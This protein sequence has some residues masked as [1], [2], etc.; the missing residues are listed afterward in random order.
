M[1][2]VNDY[3]IEKGVL[4]LHGSGCPSWPDHHL[5]RDKLG[6]RVWFM[7]PGCLRNH[8]GKPAMPP[9]R[10]NVNAQDDEVRPTH[11]MRTHNRA[12]TPEPVPT[13]GVPPILTSPHRAPRTG[14]NHTQLHE[15]EVSNTEFRQ[16]IHMLEYTLKFK[17]LARYAPEMTSSM[18]ARMRKF[19]SGLSDDLVLECHR[20]ML[21]RDMDFARMSVHMQQVEEKKKK[22]PKSRKKDRQAKRARRQTR[23]IVSNRVEK[24][25]SPDIVT[26]MLQI[27]SCDMYVLLDPRSILSYVTPY[28][29]VSFG[30]E[31][32]VITESFLV[33]TPVGDSVVATRSVP[34]V[35]KFLEV[36][37]D[38]LPGIPPDREIDFCINLLPDTRPISI[39]PCSMAP[40]ELKKLKEQLAELLDKGI[41]V[42]PQKIEAVRKWPRPTTPTDIRSFLG[43]ACYYRRFI[44]NFSSIAAPLTKLTLKKVKFLWSDS[45]EN[46]FEKLKD[47]LT[48]API[49]TL[50]EG[51]KEVKEKQVEDPILIQIKKDVGQQ[52]VLSFKIGGDGVLRYQGRLCVPDVDGLRKRILDEAHTSRYVVHP[53]STKMYQD[54]KNIYW[55]NNMKRDVANYVAKCLN[56]QQVKVEHMRPGTNHSGEDY[57]KLFIAEIVHLHR[58]PVSIISDRGSQFSSHLWRSFQ[59]GLGTQVNLSMAFHPQTDG[60]VERTIHTLEDMLRA[61]VIDFKAQ[62]H[63]KSYAD[64]RRRDL[65]F[66]VGDWVFLKVSPM[67][68]VIRFRKKGKLSPHYIGPYQIMRRIGGVAYNL[69]LPASLG[70]VHSVFH[71]SMLKKYIGDHSLVFPIEEI[72]VTDSLSYEEE[73]VQILDRQV[74]RLRNKE[75]ASVKVLWRNQKI[76]EATWESEVDMRARYPNLFDP[77]DDE[78]DGSLPNCLGNIT[79][80]R[81][82]HLGSNKLSANIP[83]SLGNLQDL[84]VLYLS[85]NNMVGSLPPEIRNLK[86]ATLIDLST[87]QF[88]NGIPREIGGLRT[89]VHLSLKHNKFQGS[90]P[91]SVR[92]M[93][94]LEFLDL[95]NNNISGIIPMSFEKLPNLKYFNV[96]LSNFLC[97]RNLVKVITSCSNLDFKALV[98][99]YMPNGSLE[100]YLFSHNYFLDISQRLSIVIDVACAL[101]YLH[102]GCSSPVIH[103]DLKPSNV[104]LDEYMV[105]HLCEFGISK[106]LGEDE[107]DLYNKTLATLGYIAPEYGRDG[108]V[109]TKC[110]VYSYGIIFLETFTRRKP[111]EFEGDLSLKQWL[112]DSE[113]VKK[114]RSKFPADDL[115]ALKKNA[116]ANNILVCG[117][118]PFEYNR[119]STYTTAKKIWDALVN[120]HK[121]TSQVRKFKIALLFTEF[122]VFKMK[123]NESLHE[124]VTR[125][126]VLTNELT[127]LGKV[128]TEEEQVEKE[129]DLTTMTLDELV[130]NLR[131][132]EMEIYGTNEKATPVKVLNLKASDSD[133]EVKLDQEQVTFITKNFSNFFKNEREQNIV[134]EENCTLKKQVAQPESSKN[135]LKSEVLKLT[136]TE[137][138]KKV[139]SKEQE[140]TKLELVKYKQECSVEIDMVNKISQEVSKLKLDLERANRWTNSLRIVHK[141][142]KRNYSE[143]AGLGFHKSLDDPK[144][145]CYIYGNLGHPTTECLVATKSRSSSQNLANKFS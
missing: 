79:S 112:V 117:L 14:A 118:G 31:P 27:F 60:Q 88:S 28:V 5:S 107:S 111:N 15:G 75:I 90:I 114:L 141:L 40:A 77:M 120:A 104:L 3:Q 52:K 2:V 132:Y 16:S 116:K 130:G 76:E 92:N 125:L 73:P 87:N 56:C 80:L 11:G 23:V 45:C 29:A 21:N 22:I 13:L 123:E 9:H 62:S 17:K 34:I 126:T 131:T 119:L 106:L 95:S 24:E 124:I 57:D 98:L 25:A 138:G 66:K 93:V 127:S 89:L 59:K 109:S 26:G 97:H 144:D 100:K 53:G 129:K 20:A 39:L 7:V 63:Q 6:I 69:E 103:C 43:L 50:P 142:S 19:A 32:D 1:N 101:E 18:R 8:V 105:A 145:L 68:G 44:K 84:V 113:Q 135:G 122:E 81:E 140:S 82:I 91:D 137:N 74:I 72:K 38:D 65:E 115:V 64:V 78:I 42:D 47:K 99:E 128:I 58:A 70:S 121:G 55:W 41:K 71:I 110:D 33:S 83:P 30:F 54:L 85:S 136:L 4:G 143:K 108:L 139:M 96:S 61:C 51:T 133:D 48:S 10:T 35:N 102:H 36:F 49:L 12:H 37:P 86:A 134:E 94:G 67:K 46:S